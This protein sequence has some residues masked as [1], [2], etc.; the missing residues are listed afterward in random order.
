[1]IRALLAILVLLPVV[2]LAEGLAVMLAISGPQTFP[3]PLLGLVAGLH[4]LGSVAAAE[5]LALRFERETGHAAGAWYLG[6]TLTLLLPAFGM[7]LV[8]IMILRPPRVVMVKEDDFLSPME[9]RAQQ[10]EKELA[11]EA[12][13][14]IIG[15]NIEAIEEATKD[16]QKAVRLG[17]VE[18]ASKL[19]GK[20]AVE[21][22]SG[23][24]M[25]TIFEVRFHAV[26][27][28]SGINKK[29]S[30]RI[31]AATKELEA[32]QT[33]ANYRELGLIYHEFASLGME[34][35]SIQAHLYRNAVN[36]LREAANRGAG[37]VEVLVKL[38]SGLESVGE[39]GEARQAYH[40]ILQQD[41]S[42]AEALLGLAQIQYAMGEF[43]V[44]PQTC[45]DILN[46]VQGLEQQQLD[47]LALWAE[48]P[49]AL[50]M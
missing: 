47:V 13:K 28:L 15:S 12:D 41:A 40:G 18:A 4:L 50:G 31:A 16:E 24:V 19:G 32:D 23:A 45:R 43:N 38:A 44:L 9:F 2:V 8:L 25:N 46:R 22:L 3:L 39:P 7:L 37:T 1:M 10:A 42:N 14:G 5:A 11:E 48:G 17:A 6:F 29:F 34:D 33:P 30:Q 20:Q 35:P 26:E 49:E 27:A 21:I 36:N